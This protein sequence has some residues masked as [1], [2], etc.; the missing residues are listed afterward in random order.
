MCNIIKNDISY[1]SNHC[2]LIS[3][4]VVAVYC[5]LICY[6]HFASD[7]E[8]FDVSNYTGTRVLEI[9]CNIR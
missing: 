5:G 3:L 4:C 6:C 8:V 1:P 9:M 2:T 7:G